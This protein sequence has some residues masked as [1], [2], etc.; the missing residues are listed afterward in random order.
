MT[1]PIVSSAEARF[2]YCDVCREPARAGL[3][4]LKG[5]KHA[6]LVCPACLRELAAAIEVSSGPANGAPVEE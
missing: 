5:W 4:Q 3:L 6:A 1:S 2:A